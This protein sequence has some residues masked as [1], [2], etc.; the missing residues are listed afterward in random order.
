[1]PSVPLI[2]LLGATASGKSALALALAQHM[3]VEIISVD[4]LQVYRRV[5]IG[6]AKPSEEQQQ[7]VRH[8]LIDCCE[9]YEVFS[10]GTFCAAVPKLVAEIVE[11][12]NIPILVGGTMMYFQ[13]LFQG[14]SNLPATDYAIREKLEA[15]YQSQ[16]LAPLW[17]RLQDQDP[18]SAARIHPHD[19]QRTLRALEV[20]QSTG[21]SISDF[22]QSRRQLI[23]NPIC[24][25]VLQPPSKAWLHQRIDERLQLMLAQ[26]WLDEVKCLLEDTQIP[27]DHTIF[28]A[29]GYKQLVAHLHGEIDASQMREQA[30][31]QTCQYAKRQATWLRRYHHA[32][33]LP[34]ESDA[35]QA[36][37]D[38]Y[39]G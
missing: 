34:A 19:Y 14:V 35:V 23:E 38:N 6:S 18:V 17:Q 10:L 31:Y 30:Y 39:P 26:G 5:D 15:E 25:Y 4:S 13:A 29:V 27:R 28:K 32:Q 36:I 16:G 37:L 33:V 1:M 11:R 3:R 7:A 22:H 20:L 12:G 2:A 24:T 21:R 8:H 9:P